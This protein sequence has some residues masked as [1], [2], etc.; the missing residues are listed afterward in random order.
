MNNYLLPLNKDQ[1]EAV[2]YIDG[3][4]KIIA[5]AGSGKTKTLT[6]KIMYHIDKLNT[7]PWN[8]L[9][10]TFTNKAAREMKERIDSELGQAS[11]GLTLKTFHSFAT[12]FLRREIETLG[13]SKNFQIA[14]ESDSKSILNKILKQNDID[15]EK[16]TF[17]KI[18]EYIN[19]KKQNFYFNKAMKLTPNL[20]VETFEFIFD[21]Y[22]NETRKNN[23]IDFDDLLFLTYSILKNYEEIEDRW[24]NKFKLIL[25]DEFQDTD[26]VQYEIVKLL[27]KKSQLVIVGDPDQTIY[28]WRGAKLDIIMNFE[29]DFPNAKIV[30]LKQNYRSTK[31]ILFH[32]NSLIKKNSYRIEKSLYTENEEGSDVELRKFKD[33]YEEARYVAR[34]IKY[35]LRSGVA[36]QEIVILYRAHYVSKP[37]EDNLRFLQIPY[38]VYS[39]IQFYARKEIKEVISFLNLIL[40]PSDF[41]WNS[42]I[43]IPNRGIGDITLEKIN[44]FAQE[45]RISLQE[46]I[47]NH[48]S[49]LPVSGS[50]QEKIESL[51]NTIKQAREKF[52]NNVETWSLILNNFLVAID[53]YHF[54]KESKV[55]SSEAIENIR[56]FFEGLDNIYKEGI[57]KVD[58]LIQYL[59]ETALNTD[60]DEKV[61]TQKIS[62]MTVHSAKGL[63]FSHVFLVTFNQG[64]FPSF[65]SYTEDKIENFDTPQ[66][67]EERRLAYV[68][69]TRAKKALYISYNT[70]LSFSNKR[71]KKKSMF[72]K[73]MNL[74]SGGYL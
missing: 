63:E 42:M 9:G 40:N 16:Y 35:L 39:G 53:Y 60:S 5:G 11:E 45:K 71:P 12:Y 2:T 36:A 59:T 57:S 10:L 14:D 25:V 51:R 66:M 23:L 67:A 13:L 21:Q 17:F 24:S 68:A 54:I 31:T 70:E 50:L 27:S 47:D 3:P 38:S 61:E 19:Q 72:I 29:N 64:I 48:L 55:Y 41:L 26:N 74:E 69:T 7:K 43:N 56:T 73:E 58:D 30:I 52:F 46:A 62:L 6:T 33:S 34:E 37:F 4:L 65:R 28:T 18:K 32:A 1:Y 15:S 8:I 44:K 49:D 20:K 22:Q